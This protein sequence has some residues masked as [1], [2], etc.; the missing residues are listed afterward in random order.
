MNTI[1]QK[2]N[3]GDKIG[4]LRVLSNSEHLIKNGKNYVYKHKCLCDC[5]KKCY[6]TSYQLRTDSKGKKRSCG[7]MMKANKEFT[8]D[9]LIRDKIRSIK[10]A[11]NDRGHKYEL[12]YEVAA[13]LIKSPCFYCGI[14]S[15]NNIAKYV[16]KNKRFCV[17]GIDRLINSEGYTILNSVSCCYRCN[18]AKHTMSIDNFV[19]LVRRIY[20]HLNLSESMNIIDLAT[21]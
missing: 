3:I 11:A 20:S 15:K 2:I 10:R 9:D 12:S 14:V 17:N 18:L 21:N 13:L 7:C 1:I 6:A 5:G 16:G 4:K 19:K 8:I